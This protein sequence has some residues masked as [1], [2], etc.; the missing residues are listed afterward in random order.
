M[1]RLTVS[2]YNHGAVDTEEFYDT[3]V[4]ASKAL[5]DFCDGYFAIEADPHNTLEFRAYELYFHDS[6]KPSYNAYIEQ[7]NGSWEVGFDRWIKNGGTLD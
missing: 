3:S 6:V 5:T 7:E 4:E 1:F 2:D